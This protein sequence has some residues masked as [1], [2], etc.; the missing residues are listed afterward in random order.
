MLSDRM[1]LNIKAAVSILILSLISFALG[2]KFGN[3][4][5]LISP[6]TT[7]TVKK[8]GETAAQDDPLLP[9]AQ[10]LQK[11]QDKYVGEVEVPAL[12]EGA[13][14]GM[15]GSLKDPYSVY[16]GTKEFEDFMITI[17]GSFG[18]VGMSLGVDEKGNV[19]VVSPVEDTP[20]QRAGIL[21]RDRVVGVDDITITDQSL[22]EVVGYIRGEKGTKV[23]IYIER[24][25]NKN[26]LKFDLVREDIRQKTVKQEML[27]KDVGY[28]KIISFDSH[29]HEDFAKA[30]DILKKKG[31]EG[32]VLDLRNNP[33][34]SLQESVSVAD[35]I[36]GEGLVVYTEDRNGNRLEEYYSDER[37]LGIPLVVIVNENSASASEIVAGAIQDHG[38][39]ILVGKKTFGKGSV[40]E[41]D[42]FEEGG[43]I[44]ITIAKYYIPSGRSIDGVGIVPNVE[45]SLEEDVIYFDVP[46]EK[47]TQLAKALEVL[48]TIMDKK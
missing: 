14:K 7:L 35:E 39:G 42:P 31:L 29:T 38:A 23:T 33:G 44:K 47:D 41:L 20:A 40:Q 10:V 48:K 2:A 30:I 37:S 18:G 22:D 34:G 24:D 17:N 36:L 11:I 19:V 46:R 1:K 6:E 5:L 28:V 26:P 9:L 12:V 3:K 13:I 4:P 25:E 8:T 32:L 21:P 15:V 27:S 16:M 43:G 45:I